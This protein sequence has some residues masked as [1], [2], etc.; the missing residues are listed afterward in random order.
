M[1]RA[2]S[3][4]HRDEVG[5]WVAELV[6]G[7]NQHVRHKP[8]WTNRPWVVTPAGRRSMLGHELNC[9][10]CDASGDAPGGSD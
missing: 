6:C 2:I 8:P 7:H 9:K 4:Y 3:G 10:L 5:D 1:K